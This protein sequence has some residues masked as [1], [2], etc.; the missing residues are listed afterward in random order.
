MGLSENCIPKLSPNSSF[1]FVT[2]SQFSN[3][4][5]FLFAGKLDGSMSLHLIKEG[6]DK[7]RGIAVDSKNR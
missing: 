3:F 6:L 2:A 5:G 4:Q 7:P 1:I